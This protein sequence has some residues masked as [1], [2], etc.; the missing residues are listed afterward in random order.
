MMPHRKICTHFQMCLSPYYFFFSAGAQ[1]PEEE[2]E[3]EEEIIHKLRDK[4]R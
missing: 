1:W 4:L 3:K 2:D